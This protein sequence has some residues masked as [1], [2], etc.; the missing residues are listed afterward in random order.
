MNTITR[1]MIRNA[2]AAMA[3]AA[4]RH[5][6]LERERDELIR[7]IWEP[8]AN[9]LIDTQEYTERSIALGSDYIG[10]TTEGDLVAWG[11][12]HAEYREFELAGGGE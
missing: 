4:D 10:N 2:N 9:A 12:E 7:E 11:R 6:L 3:E 1:D 5:D 8:L